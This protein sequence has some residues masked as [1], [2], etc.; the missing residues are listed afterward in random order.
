MFHYSGV[1]GFVIAAAGAA[2]GR[3]VIFCGLLWSDCPLTGGVLFFDVLCGLH[4]YFCD[5]GDRKRVRRPVT[6]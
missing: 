6:G 5:S 2:V 1:V 3:N 4:G